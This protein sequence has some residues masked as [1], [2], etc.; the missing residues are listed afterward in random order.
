VELECGSFEQVRVSGEDIPI[1]SGR[2]LKAL[3]VMI[4][5]GCGQCIFEL[6]MRDGYVPGAERE[7]DK[8]FLMPIEDVFSIIG[9]AGQ[10]RLTGV[11]CGAGVFHVGDDVEICGIRP[12]LKTGVHR[13][14]LFRQ[15]VDEARGDNI[16]VC[17]GTSATRWS[18]AGGGQAGVDHAA[19]EVQGGGVHF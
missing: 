1:I 13:V 12:T 9:G 3:E 2:A 17:C 8:P 11:R 19:H 4:R 14:E 18:G 10:K 6:R 5:R 16:G 15:V 7:I